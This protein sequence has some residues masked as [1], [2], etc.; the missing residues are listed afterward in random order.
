[1]PTEVALLMRLENLSDNHDQ[2]RSF[3]VEA[4]LQSHSHRD[5]GHLPAG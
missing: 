5:Q 1:M 2:D 3:R 4:H